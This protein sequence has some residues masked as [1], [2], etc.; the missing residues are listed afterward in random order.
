MNEVLPPGGFDVVIVGGGFAGSSAALALSRQGAS[1]CLIDLQGAPRHAFR[2]EKFSADQLPL[3]DTLGLLDPFLRVT[4]VA[5]QAVNIRGTNVVD[6]S[7][8]QD[9]GLMYDDMVRT[10]RAQLATSVVFVH[11]KVASIRPD[12]ERSEVVLDDGRRVAARLVVLATGHARALREQLGILRRVVHPVPTINVGFTIA[13]PPQ[14]FAFPSLAAYGE[15]TGDGVDYTSIFPIGPNMRVNVFVFGEMADPRIRAFQQDALGALAA[16]QPGLS[17]WLAGCQVHG[18]VDLFAVELS[19]S[20]GSCQ[21]GL[22]VIGD[23]YRTACSAVGNGLTCLLVDVVRLA[24]HVPRWL[25]SPGMGLDKVSQFYDDP[26]KKEMDSSAHQ[27]ALQRRNSVLDQHRVNRVR[28]DVHFVR[29]RLA[30][31]LAAWHGKA[32]QVQPP[33]H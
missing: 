6:I 31:R 29:R 17:P 3:L 7:T 16:L 18:A 5:H 32:A 4:S 13:P 12:A 11:G 24:A 33:A 10:L 27:M 20:E 26:I 22:A 21:P 25:A 15:V 19:I 30:F 14:G 28:R 1:V 23:A 8:V 9:H 2:A